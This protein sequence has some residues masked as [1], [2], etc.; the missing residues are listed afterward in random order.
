MTTASTKFQKATRQKTRL[1]LALDGPSGSGKS[2]TAL[3]FAQAITK[4]YGGRIAVIDTEGGS[5]SL[6]AG[7]CFDPELGPL[8]FDVCTMTTYSPS[9]YAANIE[10]AGRDGFTVILVDSLS[11]AW[12][13][14]DGALETV[15][16]LTAESRSRNAYTQG[17]KDVTPM[18][19]RM[20]EAILQSPSHVIVTMR[21]KTEYVIEK[22]SN[23]RDVPR[24]IGMA[25]IQRAGMEYEFT[26]YGSLNWSHVL[27]VT[28][29][30]CAAVDGLTAI[31]PGA[32]WLQAVL[33]WMDKGEATTVVATPPSLATDGQV[34][35]I[36]N[37]AKRIGLAPDRMRKE[38]IKRYNVKELAELRGADAAEYIAR[39]TRELPAPTEAATT[40]GA[41]V[42][43]SINEAAPAA[44]VQPA[45]ASQPSPTNGTNQQIPA[46]GTA[47]EQKMKDLF[48]DLTAI[49]LTKEKWREALKKK[50][51]VETMY[52][53]TP[54]QADDW[55][56]YL[57][58]T[59][60]RA[61]EATQAVSNGD[62]KNESE[63]TPAQT[64]SLGGAIPF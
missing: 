15:D 6:Y 4:R 38:L 39:L 42:P 19:R 7:E 59:K 62:K 11:H 51:G 12:E 53:L 36:T 56:G 63:G 34:L 30:R 58:L 25:P 27:T 54:G 17:W 18:H 44:T 13:G 43:A 40:A 26:L 61:N 14:K 5:A 16:K 45:A 20:V 50:F 49:G 41:P 57:E 28:K 64:T 31:K 10:Q 47:R 22:D 52:A 21:S 1:R 3:R 37:L 35:E 23:G 8:D 55:I 2:V 32:T 46:I 48:H 9:E 24:K 29:S 33:D 60:L